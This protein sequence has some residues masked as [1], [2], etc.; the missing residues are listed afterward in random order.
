M[1]EP[2]PEVPAGPDPGPSLVALLLLQ[3]ESWERGEPLRIENLLARRPGLRDEP[4][5]VLD[6]IYNEIMLREERGQTPRLTDYLTRFSEL[7]EPLRL[8]FEVDN[9]L[10]AEGA[11]QA[12]PPG[13]RTSTSTWVSTP[14][15]PD[16]DIPVVPGCDVMGELGRGAMGTVFRAWQRQPNRIVALKLLN[17]GVPAARVRTEAE[18]AA[19]LQHGNIVQVFEVKE[20]AGR[21]CLVLEYVEGGNLARKIDG[22]P[23]PP[24]EA[25]LLVEKLGRA[26]AYAHA[27]GVIHRDLKP[28]NVLLSGPPEAAL[29]QCEPKISD[30][31]L[32]KLV[33]GIGVSVTRTSDI[34]GTPSYMSPEQAGEGK[35][36]GPAADTYALGAILYECLTGR[37]PFL[38]E[39]VLDTLAQLRTQEPVPPRRLQPKVP[40]DLETICLK[41]L[42]KQP[43]RRYA[44]CQ[45]LADDLRRYLQ[46]ESIQA[47]P[48]G[49]LERGRKW[50]QRRPAAAA[51]LAVSLA[52][53]VLLA[54]GGIYANRQVREQRDVA[55][56][57]ANELDDQLART[58][59]LLFTAQLLRVGAVWERDPI[60]GQQMLEDTASF[61]PD[62]RDFAWGVLYARCKRYRLALPGHART[63]AALAYRRDGKLLASGGHDGT[64][65]L[66]DPVRGEELANLHEHSNRVVAIAFSPDG[67]TLASGDQDGKIILWDVARRTV[68]ASL[69]APDGAVA[70]LA[71]SPDGKTLAANGGVGRVGHVTLW[72]VKARRVRLTLQPGTQPRCTVAFSRDGTQ[73]ACGSTD[74]SV[75]VWDPRTGAER[76]P[77]RGHAE[78]VTCVAFS[79]DGGTLAAGA[80]DGGVR[81]WDAGTAV[82]VANFGPVA[83]EDGSASA[84]AISRDGQ[85]LAASYANRLARNPFGPVGPHVVQ[86][87][88]LAK[89]QPL[90]ALHGHRGSVCALAI[91]PDGRTIATGGGGPDCSVRLWDIAV[92]PERLPLRGHDGGPGTVVMIPDGRTLLWASRAARPPSRCVDVTVWDAELDEKRWLLQGH[93]EP[94]GCLALSRDGRLL[95]TAAGGKEDKP[96]LRLWDLASG[97]LLREL[98]APA[99]LMTGLAFS[100]DGKKL[101][102]SGWERT[103]SLWDVESGRLRRT[104]HGHARPVTCVAFSPDGRMLAAGEDQ[105]GAAA[106]IRLWDV[107]NRELMCE[108]AG[109]AGRVTCVAFAPDGQTLASGGRDGTIRLW[110]VGGE[111]GPVVLSPGMR[112]VTCLAYSPNGQTLAA[113]GASPVVKLYDARMGQE[114]VSLPGHAGGVCF[115]SFTADGQTL[116]AASLGHSLRWWRA[117]LDN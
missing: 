16:A 52:A 48:V 68:R 40:R 84:V 72:D 93:W 39:T 36:I 82:Q 20:Q 17:S 33:T 23:Q 15:A 21:T 74:R 103:V 14:P 115:V 109:H 73:V 29:G 65:K 53:V 75:R 88:D 89:N 51:L 102:G 104:L 58:R 117:A 19:R 100:P 49:M 79:P 45:Q 86:L 83:V 56:R 110:D 22:R 108:L 13:R 1:A 78:A 9:A 70:A 4:D 81:L 67:A 12:A 41:C 30:F 46:G 76:R 54:G 95:A 57:Q 5:A 90:P 37:P 28:S 112:E 69:T 113:G 2:A 80:D 94:I 71:Y 96:E 106:T 47:R 27:K 32:A 63:V 97:R 35:K 6:L 26:M 24:R 105:A 3:R 77:M 34:L 66:W 64:V 98:A 10:T 44:S 18:A 62:Q 85:T 7:A 91:S 101:A 50:A 43:S 111:R 25:A 55:R 11:R 38:G 61:P 42:E 99:G 114:R 87:W 60:Q 116:A 31:G 92:R 59:R 8:Q 107:E